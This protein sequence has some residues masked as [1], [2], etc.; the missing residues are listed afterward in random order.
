MALPLILSTT[1]IHPAPHDSRQNP[2]A[3]VV[4]D[5][6]SGAYLAIEDRACDV[7]VSLWSIVLACLFELVNDRH[8]PC[9]C[10]GY[11]FKNTSIA[12]YTTS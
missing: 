12:K 10:M 11:F 2:I 7:T 1:G 3:Y 8:Q 4:Q 6:F 9:T 5:I